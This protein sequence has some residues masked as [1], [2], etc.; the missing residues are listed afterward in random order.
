MMTETVDDSTTRQTKPYFLALLGAR[1]CEHGRDADGLGRL[2][3]GL[4]VSR[5][6]TSACGSRCCG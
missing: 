6:P 5:E 2:D 3:E 1:L 4:A